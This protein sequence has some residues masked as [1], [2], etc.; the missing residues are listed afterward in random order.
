MGTDGQTGRHL[1]LAGIITAFSVILIMITMVMSWEL[2]MVPLF[3]MSNLS[4]WFLHIARLGSGGFYENLCAGLLMTEFF[5]FGVH[6][7]SLFDMPG[8][9]CIMVLALFK[10]LQADQSIT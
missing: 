2:W 7:S 9:A 5:F 4:V 10:G 3:M 8:V 1:L 6:E